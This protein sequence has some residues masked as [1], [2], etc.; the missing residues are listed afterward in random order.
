MNIGE[1]VKSLRKQ[2]NMSLRELAQ[3]TGLSKTTLS[4]LEN[5]TKNPSLDTVEK[6]ATAFGLTSSDLLQKTDNPED[7]V[8]SA[9]DSSSE[10]LAG[11]SK[12]GDLIKVLYRAKDAPKETMD[13]M[14]IFLDTLLKTQEQKSENEK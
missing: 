2:S 10:L 6:I 14:A 8:S 3:N 5:G 9:K 1:K 12:S 11:L 7:L 4:D 13:Q